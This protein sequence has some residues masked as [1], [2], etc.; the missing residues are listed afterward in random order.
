M[1]LFGM[2]AYGEISAPKRTETPMLH[3]DTYSVL[4]VGEEP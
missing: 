2:Y 1:R 3:N 4:L